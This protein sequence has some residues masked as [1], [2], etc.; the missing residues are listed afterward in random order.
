MA[1]GEVE[2]AVVEVVVDLVQEQSEFDRVVVAKGRSSPKDQVWATMAKQS[3]RPKKVALT[4]AHQAV[5]VVVVTTPLWPWE[6][7]EVDDEC[8]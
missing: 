4:V 6:L 1:I 2:L 7:T 3:H 8:Q 5:S